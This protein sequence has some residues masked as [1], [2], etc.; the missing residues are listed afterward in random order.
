[1]TTM[2]SP[3][4]DD[5]WRARMPSAGRTIV[6]YCVLFFGGIL[7][8]PPIGL[9]CAAIHSYFFHE[10]G[11][12]N[13]GDASDPWLLLLTW[14][15]P[16]MI[17]LIPLWGLLSFIY[18]TL[19]WLPLWLTQGWHPLFRRPL[20]ATLAG[21]V[22][23]VAMLIGIVLIFSHSFGVPATISAPI[24]SVDERTRATT[25]AIGSITGI[26]ITGGIAFLASCRLRR[27]HA[28]LPSDII[29]A[30]RR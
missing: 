5:H 30:P 18:C 20:C 24:P 8:G 4:P 1:M 7:I 16:I 26:A 14:G 28:L 13:P 10:P 19:I 17:L 23:A 11:L 12:G 2:P 27:R 22:L 25:V 3:M 15:I 6:L 9:I 29:N 21:A